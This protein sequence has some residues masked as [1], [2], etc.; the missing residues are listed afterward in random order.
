MIVRFEAG[1]ARWVAERQ[2]FTWA[3]TRPGEAGVIMLYRPRVFE[4]IEGWLLSWGDQMEVLEPP[5]LRE[6]IAALAARIAGR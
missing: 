5:A 2:H 3:E 6:R 1:V 4:Q